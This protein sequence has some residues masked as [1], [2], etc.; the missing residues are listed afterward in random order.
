MEQERAV[1]WDAFGSP[2]NGCMSDEAC[3][4]HGL[5]RVRFTVDC[6]PGLGKVNSRYADRRSKR[7]SDDWMTFFDEVWLAWRKA[8]SPI[9]HEGSLGVEVHVYWGRQRHLDFITGDG[10]VDALDK[11][12]LDAMGG[13]EKA[14]CELLDDD[15]R[16]TRFIAEKYYDKK[17]PRVEIGIW[18]RDG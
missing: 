1:L 8:G 5:R 12:V 15:D 2:C 16:V 9:C 13:S 10:D 18:R 17:N 7:L 4:V 3:E 14:S 6:E 11:A